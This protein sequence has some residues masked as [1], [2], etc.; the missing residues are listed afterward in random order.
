MITVSGED[1]ATKGPLKDMEFH[2]QEGK[3]I[4][5]PLPIYQFVSDN[6]NAVDLRLS[7]EVDSI[8]EIASNGWL[9]LTGTLDREEKA[10][11]AL[12]LETINAQGKTV[13][14]PYSINIIVDD[15]ND[16]GPRFNQT[17]YFGTVRQ[18]YRPGKP[19]LQVYATDLDDPSTP[20]AK[21]YYSIMRQMP[22]PYNKPLFSIDNKMGAISLT[23]E[24]YR[25]LDPALQAKFELLVTVK[26][27]EGMSENAFSDNA[28]VHITVTD[29]IWQSPD[30][31]DVKENSTD[32][33][34]VNITKVTW[35]DPGVKYELMEKE[36]KVTFQLPF[37]IDQDGNIYVTKPLDREEKDQYLFFAAVK[38]MFGNML[39]SPVHIQVNVLDINDNPPICEKALTIFEVQENEG[40]GSNI[41]TLKARDMDQENDG[42]SL[43]KFRILDQN[44]KIPQNNIF[45]VDEY[46]GIFQLSTAGL[47]K[48]DAHQYNLTVEVSDDGSPT[49]LQTI[50]DLQI[51]VIDINNEIPIFEKSDYGNITLAEDTL[52]GTVILEIQATDADEPFTGSSAIVYK[53]KE[54]DQ[55]EDFLIKTNT[56]TNRGYVEINKPL[57]FE[58]SP[59][60]NLVIQATN[61]EPLAQGVEYTSKSITHFNIIVTNVNEGPI[62]NKSI[63][64]VQVDEDI[65]VGTKLMTAAAHDPE[66]DDIRFGLKYDNLNWLKIDPKTGDIFSAAPLDRETQSTYEVQ[67]FATETSPSSLSSS[68]LFQLHLKDVNDNAPRL[69]KD[70]SGTF[71]CHPIAKQD[72]LIIE[73]TDDD[74]SRYGHKLIFELGEDENV[75]RDWEISSIN[76]TY[77]NLSMKHTNFEIQQYPVSIKIKERGTSPLE[78]NVTILVNICTCTK[79]HTCFHEIPDYET[80]NIIV[81]LGILFGTLAFI[82][83]IVAVVFIR[84]NYKKKEEKKVDAAFAKTPTETSQLRI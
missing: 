59:V 63:Y 56:T 32:P 77:A 64:Q 72:S 48:K 41:G 54:G 52:V 67:V 74:Y 45:R 16:N 39:A 6:P 35:N 62:F 25:K 82:G 13:E 20:N 7:G 76:G 28:K 9:K 68:V 17:E 1:E 14:G 44:P 46:T 81:A 71:F 15:I 51:H 80:Q 31:I 11:Y 84:I 49:A 4:V 18:G 69:A 36:K 42:N 75:K 78:A 66:G 83:V 47:Q 34:P 19:F 27:L 3:R 73:A 23:L 24:G 12:K 43:L 50:C 30:P 21:L 5:S 70:Y 29:N 10:M 58:T 22:D 8:F 38:D 61:P 57:D 55:Q 26:D 2:I 40:L 37:S 60:Y 65:P 53:V 33:H 79:S